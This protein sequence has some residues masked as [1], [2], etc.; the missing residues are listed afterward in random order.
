M[1][2]DVKLNQTGLGRCHYTPDKLYKEVIE[3][4]LNK[5]AEAQEYNIT[6]LYDFITIQSALIKI[7]QKPR[8]RLC[9]VKKIYHIQKGALAGLGAGSAVVIYNYFMS[10]APIEV[11]PIV[12]FIV[13]CIGALGGMATLFEYSVKKEERK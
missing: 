10:M 1:I 12:S 13:F 2:K 5:W 6:T 8:C 9:N 4:R 3:K 11:A 7:Q